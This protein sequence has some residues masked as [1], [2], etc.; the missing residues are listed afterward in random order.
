MFIPLNTENPKVHIERLSMNLY[1]D[2]DLKVV[3]QSNNEVLQVSRLPGSGPAV[4]R[5][6]KIW[7]GVP[8]ARWRAVGR[9]KSNPMYTPSFGSTREG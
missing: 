2:A 6:K 5:K 7:T 3:K 1:V 9:E 4:Q 8:T